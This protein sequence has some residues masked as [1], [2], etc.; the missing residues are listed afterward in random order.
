ML[1]F[2]NCSVIYISQESG[3]D[4]FLGYSPTPDGN[5]NGPIRTISQLEHMI[6]S[7]R[8]CGNYRP[9][10]VRFMGD[11]CLDKPL[12]LGVKFSKVHK[13]ALFNLSD[14]TFEAYGDKKARIIGGKVLKGLKKDVFNGVD[15]LS[16][17]IP[18]VE[19]GKWSFTDLYVNGEPAKRTRYPK[20]TTLKA[21]TTEFPKNNGQ[22]FD[23]LEKGSKWF[24][25][26]KEDL[27]H[28]ENLENAIVSFYHYWIDE[29]SPVES[30]DCETG[31][32]TLKYRTRFNI[33]TQ[34]D[35]DITSDFHYYLEN[36]P[37]GFSSAGEWYLDNAKGMLYYIPK[38]GENAENLEIIAPTVKHFINVCGEPENKVV[39][40]C[41]RNLEFIATK[42]EY[43]SEYMSKSAEEFYVSQDVL[44]AAD[45]Q[46]SRDAHGAFQFEN[47]EDCMLENCRISCS[48][49]YAVDIYKGCTSVNVEKCEIT[50]SGAGGVKIWGTAAN[51]DDDVRA[52]GNCKVCGNIIK[53]CG[54]RYAA[55]CGV[56]V[57]HSAHNEISENEIAHLEYTGVSV[58]W[59]WGYMD[60]STYGNIVRGNHIHHIGQGKLSD[61]GGIYLLGKQHGTR[62]EN[63][64]IHDI[65]SKHY[66]AVGIYTDE[67][68]SYT[69]IENNIVYNC[70][71]Y[72]YQHHFGEYNVLRKNVFAF[73]GDSLFVI[74]VCENNMSTACEENVFITDGA[75]IYKSRGNKIPVDLCSSNN[76]Y[77]DINEND[78]VMQKNENED[79]T[80]EKWQNEYGFDYGS[81]IEKPSDIILKKL[82][83]K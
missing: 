38:E 49:V 12:E 35:E 19:D 29:H 52:T 78:I 16:L 80:F 57:V 25:A 44:Y 20:A 17:Y 15:C 72:C 18:E 9:I 63:N 75:P 40:I 55:S 47:A 42:G 28:I 66:G 48:G 71:S 51:G 5:G 79:I 34:Y 39:G 67:G 77:W 27:K 56:I 31:K 46:S 6:Y 45:V 58:G 82:A 54:K 65:I 50:N 7:M 33:T 10:T 3:D 43:I 11:Y 61:L 59:E 69:T 70:K 53:H 81:R 23:S 37:N 4:N 68:T 76:Y 14:V 41:I 13:T 8:V 24:V 74:S 21:V 30:Y 60:S 1:N 62:V 32:V 83:I 26:N 36:I 73:A 22:V 2:K 64:V